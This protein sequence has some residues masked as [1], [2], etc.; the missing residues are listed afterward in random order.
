[1][2]NTAMLR[3]KVEP[4]IRAR[5]EVE[6]GQP[7]ASTVLALPA[8]ARREFDAV[9]GDRTIVASIKTSSGLTSGGNLPTGKIKSCIADLYYLSLVL[10]DVRRLVLTNPEFFN[11]FMNRMEGA[12]APGIEVVL[13]PLGSELQA[14]VDLVMAAASKEMGNSDADALTP[15]TEGQA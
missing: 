11:I 7:F 6:F 4:V 3:Y 14:E 5:L 15:T 9:S 13:S 1:M 10:A 8:G 12:I 2:A